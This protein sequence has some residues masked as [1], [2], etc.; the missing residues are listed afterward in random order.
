M[1]GGGGSLVTE[2]H[3]HNL[4]VLSLMLLYLLALSL[5][6]LNLLVLSLIL[7]DGRSLAQAVGAQVNILMDGRTQVSN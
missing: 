1:T 4:L 3:P 2:G 7:T 5:M 6:L